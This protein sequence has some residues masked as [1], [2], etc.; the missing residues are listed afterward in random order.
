MTSISGL[1]QFRLVPGLLLAAIAMAGCATTQTNKPPVHISRGDARPDPKPTPTPE[2]TPTP[3][4]DEGDDPDTPLIDEYDKTKY[5]VKPAYMADRDIK[6]VGGL[7]P[8]SHSS[9]AVREQAS[10]ILAAIEMALFDTGNT[11]I[12]LIP[13]DTGG[14]PRKT[15]EVTEKVIDEGA[16]IIIGPLFSENVRSTNAVAHREKV[17][18]IAF[19]NDNSVAGEGTYLMSFQPEEEVA[20]IV[21][22]TIAQG[23]NRF[24]FIG[25]DT[26]YSRRIETALRLEVTPRAGI[27]VGSEFFSPSNTAPID[28]VSRLTDLIKYQLRPNVTKVAVMIPDRG[29]RLLGVAPLL[30]YYGIDSYRLQYIGTSRWDDPTIWK[31][32]SMNGGAFASV[33]PNDLKVFNDSF[34][35]AYGRNPTTLASLG[36]DAAS[37]AMKIIEDGKI[38]EIEFLSTDGNL[39][40]NGLY[41]FRKDG[42]AE[43]GLAI[44]GI[45]PNGLELKQDAPETF[46]PPIN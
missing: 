33:S 39:G 20:K 25:P 16:S 46:D 38:E 2:P 34:R 30:P 21:E 22:W 26:E 12:L 18:V 40:A 13:K 36:Y 43:R 19:S 23:I 24:A 29:V 10:G 5:Y 44:L 9:R 31:E 3:I 4:V 1:G 8:F 17:P 6:R 41:R 28:E 32:P 7:L 35:K 11:S 42:T 15:I 45:T 14:D 37:L 27:V